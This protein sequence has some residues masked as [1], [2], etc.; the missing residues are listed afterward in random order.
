MTPTNHAEFIDCIVKSDLVEF[1]AAIRNS[2]AVSVRVDGST[3]RTVEHNVFVMANVVKCDTTMSTIF[4]GFR[5]PEKGKAIGYFECVKDVIK[6]IVPW[7]EFLKLTTSLVTDGEYL[8]TGKFNGL[9]AKIKED[10]MSSTKP[11]LP[12][13]SIW[14]IGHR[15]NLAWKSVCTIPTVKNLILITRKLAVHFRKSGNRTKELKK[16]AAENKFNRPL[17][18]PAYFEVRWSEFTFNLFNVTGVHQ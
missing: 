12:L 1:E 9:F 2:L 11:E 15:V 5:T 13:F 8:N 3:D 10:R 6:D 7:E 17:R 4:L 16:I 14:C 18:Y